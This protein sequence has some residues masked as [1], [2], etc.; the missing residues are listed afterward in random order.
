[1]RNTLIIAILITFQLNLAGQTGTNLPYSIF[2]IGEL[3]SK[4]FNRNIG[5][6]RTGIALSSPMYLNNVNPASYHTIDSISFFFDFGLS[7]DFVKYSTSYNASQ[8]GNDINMRNIA[9]GFRISRNLT[10]SIGVV[11]FSRVG[12]KIESEK[13]LE[14]TLDK[15]SLIMTGS[16]GLTQ[17]YW[18]NSYLLFKRLSLGMNI[19]YLFGTLETSETNSYKGLSTNITIDKTAYLNKLF[20]DFGFQLLLPLKDKINITL[21]GIFGNSHYLNF[22]QEILIS[23]TNGNVLEKGITQ[24]GTLRFPWYAGGGVAVDYNKK[25]TISADYL[26]RDW[27]QTKSDN[28]NFKYTRAGSYRFGAEYIPGHLNQLGFFGTLSYRLGYYYEESYL[29]IDNVSIASNGFTLGIGIPFLRNRSS[30]N[31]AYD[32]G[33][34]GTLKNGLIRERYNSVML[35]LTLHD[36]WFIK[37]KY[38]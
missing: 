27:S 18:D 35:N 34:K 25:L 28:P 17:F 22:R 11:P 4:G 36:W 26:L 38:D 13:D 21:G 12:Y 16:G 30:I 2:G 33:V 3:A 29:N 5:M 24:K 32:T 31:I 10:S 8:R 7:S 9:M 37:R 23:E 1:M 15:Y 14:G 20:I 19:S 6:G